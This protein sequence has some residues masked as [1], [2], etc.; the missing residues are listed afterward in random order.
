MHLVCI[1]CPAEPWKALTVVEEQHPYLLT[2]NICWRSKMM[3]EPVFTRIW[4]SS[5]HKNYI[6]RGPWSSPKAL[7][8]S[9][10]QMIEE[11]SLLTIM[12]FIIQSIIIFSIFF[13]QLSTNFPLYSFNKSTVSNYTSLP[14]NLQALN[15]KRPTKKCLE[16]QMEREENLERSTEILR[17]S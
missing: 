13:T 2:T 9:T 12:F 16:H 7:L 10:R 3:Q 15:L 5:H 8:L 14:F 6:V 17:S 1:G 4:P 11:S